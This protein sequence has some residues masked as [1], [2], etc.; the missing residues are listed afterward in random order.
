MLLAVLAVSN[1]SCSNHLAFV[2]INISLTVLGVTMIQQTVVCCNYLLHKLSSA[3]AIRC[4]LV[5]RTSKSAGA[6]GYV[7]NLGGCQAPAAPVLTQA[8][9]IIMCIIMH[10]DEI[11][12]KY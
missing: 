10:I 7:Q 4:Q 11:F 9:P 1:D 5:L 12:M 8:L 2:V 6:R 3:G